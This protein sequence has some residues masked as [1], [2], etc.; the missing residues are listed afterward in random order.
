MEHNI[1]RW[2]FEIPLNDVQDS[3]IDQ[4]GKNP[5]ICCGKE[6]KNPKYFVH[7]LTTG[8]LVSSEEDF[9]DSQGLHPIGSE[10]KNR[11]PNNFIFTTQ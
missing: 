9:E 4:D 8:N 3:G 7:L 1:H 5:C 6:I 11:L 10:C 2:I